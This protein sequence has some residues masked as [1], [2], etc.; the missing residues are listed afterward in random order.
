MITKGNAVRERVKRKRIKLSLA[1]KM[2]LNSGLMSLD[3]IKAKE[4]RKIAV[5]KEFR[6]L[7][8]FDKIVIENR[9]GYGN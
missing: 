7:D 8:V 1:D 3:Q 2:L 6:S 5:I 9:L 4:Q